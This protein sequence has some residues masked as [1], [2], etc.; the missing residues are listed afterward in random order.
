M[1]TSLQVT[2]ESGGATTLKIGQH[3]TKLWSRVGCPVCFD[4]PGS[5]MAQ[6]PS[7]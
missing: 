4:S 1:I 2:A 5:C 3:L 7:G 6:W